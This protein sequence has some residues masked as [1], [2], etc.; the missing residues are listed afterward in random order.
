MQSYKQFSRKYTFEK[1]L[2]RDR[3][4]NVSLNSRKLFFR[5]NDTLKR[6]LMSPCDSSRILCIIKCS[7]LVA[8]YKFC[9]I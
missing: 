2:T 1:M 7:K 5:F 9:Y 8:K 4:I 3:S 6:S